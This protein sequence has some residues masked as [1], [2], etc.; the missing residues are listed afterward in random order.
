MRPPVCDD[1]TRKT[2]LKASAVLVATP[3]PAWQPV[4]CEAARPTS[5]M[6]VPKGLRCLPQESSEYETD[7]EDEANARQLLKP[8]FVPKAQRDVRFLLPMPTDVVM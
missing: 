5:C 4:R 8:L 3:K 2:L 1:V 6:Q 7:S